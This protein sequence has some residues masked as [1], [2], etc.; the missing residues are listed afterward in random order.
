[1][2]EPQIKKKGHQQNQMMQASSEAKLD[3]NIP[4][5]KKQDQSK[6]DANTV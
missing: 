5:E 1:M 4:E 2:D 3:K 6:P